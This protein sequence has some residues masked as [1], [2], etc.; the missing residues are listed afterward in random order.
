MKIQIIVMNR[1]FDK[2]KAFSN[3]ERVLSK[4][5]Q[6]KSVKRLTDETNM[7]IIDTTMDVKNDPLEF[8]DVVLEPVRDLGYDARIVQIVR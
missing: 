1:N 5:R 6:V 7:F 8:A 4:V 2:T 3:I